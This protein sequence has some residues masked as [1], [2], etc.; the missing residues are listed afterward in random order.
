MVLLSQAFGLIALGTVALLAG[1]LTTSPDD[2]AVIAIAGVS[3]AVGITAFYQALAIGTMSVVAP[4][5]ATGAIVPVII[6]LGGGDH[7]GGLQMLGMAI[8]AVGIL[9]STQDGE[10]DAAR[11]R[12]SRISIG[13]ALIAAVSIGSGLAAFDQAADSGVLGAVVW[14]R[15]VSVSAL[16]VVVACVRP[17]TQGSARISRE[18]L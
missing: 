9:L 4:I 10:D 18:S 17:Q 16:L 8:G 13:L 11:R 12:L 14:A 6:G 5:T 7:P 15:V 2:F 1:Q 3:G